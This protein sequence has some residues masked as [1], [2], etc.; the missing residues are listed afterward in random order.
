[1]PTTPRPQ[2][3]P[4]GCAAPFAI[5]TLAF[6]LL[7]VAGGA[8]LARGTVHT[9]TADK[10]PGV[11]AIE[12]CHSAGKSGTNCT[13]TFTPDQGAAVTGVTTLGKVDSGTRGVVVEGIGKPLLGG[14]PGGAEHNFYPGDGPGGGS[15]AWWVGGSVVLLGLGLAFV[16]TRVRF[17][18]RLLRERPEHEQ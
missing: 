2:M 16:V 17:V 6:G 10:R 12:E 5:L 13:G 4:R 1:M 8:L 3:L 18:L 14:M 9:M 11:I 15:Y 7:L